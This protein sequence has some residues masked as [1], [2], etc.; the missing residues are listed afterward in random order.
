M[1]VHGVCENGLQL[2]IKNLFDQFAEERPK[3]RFQ[4]HPSSAPNYGGNDN[5]ITVLS[6]RILKFYAQCLLYSIASK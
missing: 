5:S 3:I 2:L 4:P 6:C 1:Q